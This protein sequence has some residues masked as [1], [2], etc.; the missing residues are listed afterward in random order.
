[1]ALLWTRILPLLD[2]PECIART[3][4]PRQIDLRTFFLSATHTATSPVASPGERAT[5]TF[6]L[7]SLQR[8]RVGL[9]LRHTDGSQHVENRLALDFQFP[10]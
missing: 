8:T 3:R 6:S 9:L 10:C 1:M 5:H 2:R 4:N 7:V